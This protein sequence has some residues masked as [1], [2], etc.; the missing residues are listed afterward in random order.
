MDPETNRKQAEVF[1]AM[2][3]DFWLVPGERQKFKE[4]LMFHKTSPETIF[5]A[6]LYL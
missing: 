5:L 1:R 2:A 6:K 3:Q 4:V